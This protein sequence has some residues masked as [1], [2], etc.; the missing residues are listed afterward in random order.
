M[1]GLFEG[2]G[3]ATQTWVP[4]LDTRETDDALVYARAGEAAEDR[5]RQG[6]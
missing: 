1:N 2:N 6:L 4:T 3:Q 5:G